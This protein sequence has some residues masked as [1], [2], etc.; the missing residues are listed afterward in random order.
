[1]VKIWFHFCLKFK[2]FLFF[3]S[4]NNEEEKKYER[5]EKLKREIESER[6]EKDDEANILRQD[7][8]E[9]SQEFKEGWKRK[10]E[11]EREREKGPLIDCKLESSASTMYAH[12]NSQAEF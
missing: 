5:E 4:N 2:Q 1:M 10:G 3:L 9:N 7:H 11:R 8:P 6:S 12:L